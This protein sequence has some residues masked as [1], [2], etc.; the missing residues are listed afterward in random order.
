MTAADTLA[1]PAKSPHA[2]VAAA[3]L[4]FVQTRPRRPAGHGDPRRRRARP[5]LRMPPRRPLLSGSVVAAT[6]AR[7]S[8]W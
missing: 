4:N 8:N 2:A 3:F 1:I 7:S 5:A 6:V